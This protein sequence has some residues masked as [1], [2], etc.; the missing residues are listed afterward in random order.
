MKVVDRRTDAMKAAD[1]ELA[2]IRE[3]RPGRSGDPETT[4]ESYSQEL[5]DRLAR[6]YRQLYDEGSP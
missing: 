6:V 5:E 1:L 4:W 2:E 3:L